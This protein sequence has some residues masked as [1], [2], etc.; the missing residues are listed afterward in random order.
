MRR[1]IWELRDGDSLPGVYRIAMDSPTMVMTVPTEGKPFFGT[2]Y[3][4]NDPVTKILHA[5][6]DKRGINY[7]SVAGLLACARACFEAAPF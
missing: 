6:I 7:R 4:V 2:E 1:G 5:Y 3:S